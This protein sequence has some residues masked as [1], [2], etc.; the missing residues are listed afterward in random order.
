MVVAGSTVVVVVMVAGAPAATTAFEIV[1]VTTVVTANRVAVVVLMPTARP[2]GAMTVA[3]ELETRDVD[4]AAGQ[5]VLWQSR[6]TRQHP[7]PG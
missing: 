7:A 3:T 6:P 2:V 5:D 4:E 1:F